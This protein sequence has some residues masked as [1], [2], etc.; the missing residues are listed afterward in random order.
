MKLFR[1]FDAFFEKYVGS[2]RKLLLGRPADAAGTDG[3]AEATRG[4]G[5]SGGGGPAIDGLNEKILKV[6][7]T[8]TVVLSNCTSLYLYPSSK[9]RGRRSRGRAAAADRAHARLGC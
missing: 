5:T 7:G 1:R 4:P 2:Q 3:D 6:L 8:T 9:V